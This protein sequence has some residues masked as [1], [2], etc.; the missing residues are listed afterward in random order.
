MDIQIKYCLQCGIQYD[1][2]A[3]GEGCFDQKVSSEYCERCNAI[4]KPIIEES[5][6]KLT[7]ALKTIPRE[8]EFQWIED[9]PKLFDDIFDWM[10]APSLK[11][12]VFQMIEDEMSW[13]YCNTPYKQHKVRIGF[14]DKQEKRVQEFKNTKLLL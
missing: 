2:Q 7:S 4:A 14:N 8:W 1:Y 12:S 3:S 5:K 10:R 9:D 13:L 11:M 6:K